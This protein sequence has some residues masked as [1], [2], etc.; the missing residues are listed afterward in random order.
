MELSLR[1]H[2]AGL[3]SHDT[4]L[5]IDKL[6]PTK[7]V[8]ELLDEI[9]TQVRLDRLKFH[10]FVNELENIGS[11][12][13]LCGKLRS[14][15]C[16]CKCDNGTLTFYILNYYLVWAGSGHCAYLKPYSVVSHTWPY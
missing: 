1:L 8:H 5:R 11:M 7:Q 6:V 14:T 13:H 3:L 10:E 2:T 12:Q 9:E 15:C 16:K 4:I